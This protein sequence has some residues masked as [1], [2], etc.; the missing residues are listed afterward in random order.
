MVESY[1][2]DLISGLTPQTWTETEK[3]FENSKP[4]IKSTDAG[5]APGLS[6]GLPDLITCSITYS[7]YP[8]FGGMNADHQLTLGWNQ[9]L[10]GAAS[11]V[12]NSQHVRHTPAHS[13]ND[14]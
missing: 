13:K 9:I 2:K 4:G 12:G 8:V 10:D 11:M 5:P 3:D 14:H 1:R 7:M 6:C